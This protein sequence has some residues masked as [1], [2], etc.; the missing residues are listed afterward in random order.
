MSEVNIDRPLQ[1]DETLVAAYLEEHPD[2]FNHHP[3]LLQSLRV[4]H[5]EKGAVSLVE[6]QQQRLRHKIESLEQEITDLMTMARR[7]ERIY[8]TYVNLLPELMRCHSFAELEKRLSLALVGDLQVAEVS[9]RLNSQRFNLPDTMSEYAMSP[10]Q[11]ERLWVTRMSR[12]PYYFGRLSLG[13]QALLFRDTSQ[14]SSVAMVP[15]GPRAEFGLFTAASSDADH[16]I[17]DMDNLL[18]SQ[19]CDVIASLLPELVD[20]KAC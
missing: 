5:Q 16:Y 12:E 7:N 9:L 4:P 6:I 8:L 13:E 18:L 20:S 15:L 11:L 10:E 17:A 1:L 14:V 3:H 2:F 19:L